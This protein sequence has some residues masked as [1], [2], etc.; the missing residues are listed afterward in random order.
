M[1]PL[2]FDGR[3][4][5][6]TGAGGGVGRCHALEL[7]RRGASVVVN[8]IGGSVDGTGSG[9]AAQQVVEE[10]EACGGTAVAN[11]DSVATEDGG[12]A[13]VQTAIEAFG[14][15]DVLVNNAGILRDAS[16]AKMSV[17]QVDTVLAVHLRG[18]F[19][20]TM[21]A[22][23]IMREQG[24]GRIVN[25]T[26]GSGLFGNFGQ[27]N[28]GAAKMG[29][30]GLTRVL[31]IEGARSGIRVNAIA[32]IART[33]M[34]EQIMD[35]SLIMEGA[36]VSPVVTYLGHESCKVTG[37]IYSVGGGRV[38]RVFIAATTGIH[39]AD[40]SAEQVAEAIEQIDD[41]TEYTVR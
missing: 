35:H 13:I 28:Y 30:V 4:A 3:V 39:D 26:S 29:V 31:A 18:A 2:T 24:Y 10:I 5:I 17:E 32:P 23:K 11:M 15:L 41:T 12:K 8:D 9:P 7:A 37:Q 25:T 33:R 20:V 40:L 38:A 22:W 27:A 34:T 36:Q 1:D 14:R 16:F 6:V 21:P 19:T